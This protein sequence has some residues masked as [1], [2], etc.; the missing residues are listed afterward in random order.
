MWDPCVEY[1]PMYLM[2]VINPAQQAAT[3]VQFGRAPPDSQ[4]EIGFYA[5]DDDWEDEV[6]E[7]LDYAQIYSGIRGGRWDIPAPPT[8][9]IL[10][11]ELYPRVDLVRGD[12]QLGR[13][14]DVY[15]REVWARPAFFMEGRRDDAY[16]QY[17]DHM[18][19]GHLNP[20]AQPF[21]YPIGAEAHYPTETYDGE[22]LTWIPMLLPKHRADFFVPPHAARAVR[23]DLRFTFFGVLPRFEEEAREAVRAYRERVLEELRQEELRSPQGMEIPSDVDSLGPPPMTLWEEDDAEWRRRRDEYFDSRNEG[24][25]PG[26]V[27]R[28]CPLCRSVDLT[29]VV[30]PEGAG[31]L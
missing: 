27:P 26:A 5:H 2:K 8:W 31:G 13:E 11:I 30:A 19:Q 9:R 1:S 7:T 17:L 29:R 6:C 28:D 20:R 15:L 22:Y 24:L 12:A 4:A 14:M 3:R 18:R 25:R 21:I 16:H 10:L 23:V